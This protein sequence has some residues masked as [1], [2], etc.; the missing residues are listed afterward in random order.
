M[1]VGTSPRVLLVSMRD[2]YGVPERG[3]SY[4]YYNLYLPLLRVFPGARL[5]DFMARLRA[6][7]KE[8]MNQELRELVERERPD[9]TIVAYYTDELQPETV[10][11]LRRW[12]VTVAY[13]FDDIWRRDYASFW[14]RRVDFVATPDTGG[15]ARYAAQGIRT[16]IHAPFAFNEDVY[17]REE[18]PKEHEVSFVGGWHPYREWLLRRLER[19]GVVPVVRGAGWSSGRISTEEM[20]RLINV[21][22]VNLNIDNGAEWDP[23]YLLSSTLALK[24]TLRTKK[25]R[26]QVKGRHFEIAGCAGFQLSYD[27]AELH[28]Y[29]DVGKEIVVYRGADD[30]VVKVRRYLAHDDER[31]AIAEAAWRRARAQHTAS[32]RLRALVTEV[33]ARARARVGAA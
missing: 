5:F 14:A 16:A 11:A 10:T 4:E 12:T 3:L 28:A 24:T 1:T 26:K 7:G 15:V 18:V 8:A 21:T 19:A 27:V 17:R 6:V 22:K 13:F 9:V 33:L 20:A 29:F 32:A 23:R 2:D 30:L 25:T 31:E